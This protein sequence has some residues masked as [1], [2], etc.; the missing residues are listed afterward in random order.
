MYHIYLPI[1]V[2]CIG[3]NFYNKNI[4]TCILYLHHF[5]TYPFLLHFDSSPIYSTCIY[6]LPLYIHTPSKNDNDNNNIN[7]DI[8]DNIDNYNNNNDNNNIYNNNND[9]TKMIIVMII[10]TTATIIITIIIIIIIIT[11]IIII[12]TH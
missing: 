5:C 6:N 3:F 8:N 12:N 9:I 4:F 2:H 1:S 10:T 11:I 7:K